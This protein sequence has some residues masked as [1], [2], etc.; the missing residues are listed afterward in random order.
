[1]REALVKRVFIFHQNLFLSPQIILSSILTCI[2]Y[3]SQN[4]RSTLIRVCFLAQ[5][6]NLIPA[7]GSLM[8]KRI[9]LQLIIQEHGATEYALYGSNT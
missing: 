5:I 8:L 7:L 3:T 1:M 9:Y 2:D 6:G 4:L